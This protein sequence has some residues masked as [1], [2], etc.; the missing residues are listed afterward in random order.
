MWEE[1]WPNLLMKMKDMP[2]YHFKSKEEKEKEGTV[3]DLK[4]HFKKY[5]K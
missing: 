4:N 2:H 5:I 3:D 1:N